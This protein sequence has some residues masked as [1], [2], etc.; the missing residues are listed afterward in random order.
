VIARGTVQA[1]AR[2]NPGLTENVRFWPKAD[3]GDAD[4]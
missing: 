3:I 1:A 4:S 2:S